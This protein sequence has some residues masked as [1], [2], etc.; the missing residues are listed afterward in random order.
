[1]VDMNERY[2]RRL[3]F[4]QAGALGLSAASLSAFLAA[5]GSATTTTASSVDL[6]GP[7]A[8]ETLLEK[9]KK[10]GKLEAIGIPPE[11]ANYKD[12]LDTYT[13]KYVK[14]QYQAEA[15]FSSAQELEVFKKSKLHAHGDIG[16]VGFKFGPQAVQQGLV[17]PYK[18]SKWDDIP[19]ELKDPKGNWCT[20]YWGAQAFIINTDLVKNEPTSFKDLLNGDYKNMVGI[21]GDPREANDAF[22]SV[23]SAALATSG[24]LDSIQP[25][26]DF[27]A[28]LKKK[29]NFTVARSSLAN[30]TKGEVAIAIMWDYLG[31]GFRDQ[32]KGKPNLK[33]IIPSDGSIAG[34]YVSII[35]KTA[36]DPYAARLW[37]EYI[38]S[39]EG[40]LNY[41][42]GY[43]HPA[44][45]QALV[46]AGK[47]PTELADKLPPAEQYANVKFVTDLSKL[48]AAA[49]ALS[50]NWQSQVLGQ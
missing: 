49:T 31:L 14:V 40:Q 21:D 32:L 10:E 50:N 44:R 6:A 39:D 25:G 41:L 45:Y 36:P 29:G 23:Y 17:T 4:K 18:H 43:A 19:A 3:F 24:S 7:I 30:V 2:A 1:M 46:K 12:I 8:I 27:F 35:N 26:I 22:I 34:P 13:S 38:F 48:D 5:C 16:D 9:A 37:M 42:K 28:Q 33:V 20:E 47:V 11:W 15:E